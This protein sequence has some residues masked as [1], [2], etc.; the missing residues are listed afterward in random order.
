MNIIYQKYYLKLKKNENLK[1][2][3]KN[4]KIY[5]IKMILKQLHQNLVFQIVQI[6][7]VKLDG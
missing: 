1:K 5:K 4:I 6:K 3:I 2:N 7:V